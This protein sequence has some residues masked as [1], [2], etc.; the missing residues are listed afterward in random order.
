M[1]QYVEQSILMYGLAIIIS[2][3]VAVLIK[4]I[5]TSLSMLDQKRNEAAARNAAA[6]APVESTRQVEA[7]HI[8]AISAAIYAILGAHRI[9]RLEEE[10]HRGGSWSTAG[11]TAH[12]ASHNVPHRPRR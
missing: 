2:M 12:H 9:V 7:D 8:A 1:G 6:T 11:R 3:V 10:P 5:A 4:G